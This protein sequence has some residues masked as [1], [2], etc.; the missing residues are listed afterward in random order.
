MGCGLSVVE[1]ASCV[2]VGGHSVRDNEIKFGYAVTGLIHPDRIFTNTGARPGDVLVFTKALGTGVITTALKQGKAWAEWVEAA[3]ASMTTSNRLA[4]EL[5][6]QTDSG[7]H[8][9]TDVTGFGL[10]GHGR[11]LAFGSGVTLHIKTDA[12]QVIP[13]ALESIALGCVPAGLL[14]N[15]DYAECVVEQTTGAPVNDALNTVLYDPQ[16]AGGLLMSVDASRAPALVQA[17]QRSGYAAARVIG[18]VR[19]GAP[20]IVLIG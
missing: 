8:A 4:G 5:A 2:V 18:A 12:L 1:Q 6:A 3:V 19:N 9:M 7:V 15:R 11:E 14:S 10:M 16:T 17:L 13:G 20:K